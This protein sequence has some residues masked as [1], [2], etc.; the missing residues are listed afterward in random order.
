[1]RL[2]AAEI[3]IY[4][5]IVDLGGFRKAAH[6]LNLTQSAVSQSLKTMEKKLGIELINR[7]PPL[8]IT[9]AGRVLLDYAYEALRN[10]ENTLEEILRIREGS[11][12][13]LSL[14][15]N[16]T[17]TRFDAPELI[18]QFCDK[19]PR[20]KLKIE[21]V[22]SRGI[23]YTVLSGHA[24]LG[25]GPF[26][27]NMQSFDIHAMYQEDLV[28]VVSPQYK[29]IK[30]LLDNPEK[31]LKSIPLVVSSLDEQEQRPTQGRLRHQFSTIWE[32]TSLHVRLELLSKG[33]CVG[34]LTQKVLHQFPQFEVFS[35]LQS[36]PFGRIPRKVGIYYKKGRKLSRSAN[37][38]IRICHQHWS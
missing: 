16:S 30:Q 4:Q 28:L 8:E 1:M 23:I 32:I 26:Q 36:L 3:R 7:G 24:E 6:H 10:E 37:S 11:E 19:V 29:R 15:V 20:A 27:K 18:R 5:S 38:F 12:E 22:P 14:A 21:E 17:L 31:E 13:T 9:E 33:S 2:E 34:Y 25:L 35:E